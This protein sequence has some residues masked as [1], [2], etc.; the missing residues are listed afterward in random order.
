MA[1]T[2]YGWSMRRR[3]FRLYGELKYIEVK[4]DTA[5]GIHA[6]DLLAQLQRLED[7]A[8]H[9]QVP[10][11]F[12][13]FLYQLRNHIA[14]VRERIRAVGSGAAAPVDRPVAPTRGV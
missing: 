6:G 5:G 14:L 4:L 8:N 13:P 2:L 12:A 1:P 7:R 11:A 9:L 10:F 3:I